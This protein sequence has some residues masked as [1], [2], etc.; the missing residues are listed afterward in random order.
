MEEGMGPGGISVIVTKV[1]DQKAAYVTIDG[2]NIVSGLREK[3]L[4]EL[5][6][7]G[8]VD[9]EVLTTDTHAVCGVVRTARGYHPIGEAIDQSKL[10]NYIRQVAVKA[11]GNLEPAEASWRTEIIPSI[12]VIG[13]KRIEELCVLADRTTKQAKRLALSLFP[14]ASLLLILLFMFL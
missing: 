4:S 10:I 2:N 11:L 13:E 12:N 9:G 1:G 3:I 7:M 5:G 6:E 14:V 8:I